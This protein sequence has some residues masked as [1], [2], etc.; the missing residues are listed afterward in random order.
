MFVVAVVVIVA[1]LDD[2][3]MISID[4][5]LTHTRLDSVP[6]SNRSISHRYMVV[7][8]TVS[9]VLTYLSPY[10]LEPGNRW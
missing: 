9:R 3:D 5:L 7:V 1:V 10:V 4:P 2:V 8:I 6:T